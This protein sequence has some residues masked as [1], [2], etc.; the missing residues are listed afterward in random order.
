[1][2]IENWHKLA[3][4]SLGLTFFLSGCSFLPKQIDETKNW[5]ASKIYNKAKSELTK[6]DY[7]SAIKFL[8]KL[9]ARFP[10]GKYAQQSQI[11]ISYAYF[12][13]EDF[14]QAITAS[15]RFIKLHPSHPR[16][17]YLY[18]LKGL[19]NYRQKKSF[20]ER[21]FPVDPATRDPG[22]ARQAFFDFKVLVNKFP[23]SKYS[24]DARKRMRFLRNN[25]AKHEVLVAKYYLKRGVVV[26]A[27]NRCKFV[28]ENYDGSPSMQDAIVIMYKGY[29]KLGLKRLANDTKR[30]LALNFPNHPL[31]TGKAKKRSGFKRI[32]SKGDK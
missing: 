5:S 15:D 16:V 22:A 1:M 6:G 2:K 4:L 20:L 28:V 14:E 8:E 27:I 19:V 30:I 17:D 9:E 24:A 12:K 11:D 10:F 13:N 29:L 7:E 32:F 26:A 18:Y 21:I 3:I 23:H 31:V 25:L